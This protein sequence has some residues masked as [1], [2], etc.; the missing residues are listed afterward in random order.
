LNLKGFSQVYE[1]TRK[2]LKVVYFDTTDIL[3]HM[4]ALFQVSYGLCTLDED[5]GQK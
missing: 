1:D 3:G 4:I 5:I 2:A